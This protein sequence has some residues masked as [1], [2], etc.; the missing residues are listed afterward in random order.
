MTAQQEQKDWL[1]LPPNLPVPHDDGAVRH[2]TGLEL[3]NIPLAATDG[4]RVYL[5]RLAARMVV[6][7]YPR[8]GRQVSPRRTAGTRSPARGAAH[9]NPVGFAIT[10][11]P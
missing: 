7:A 3:P 5:A 11:A 2:L 10:S 1:E 6:Y 4:T 9:L 8:T